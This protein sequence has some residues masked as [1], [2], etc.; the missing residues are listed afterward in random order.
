MVDARVPP[1]KECK[2][3]GKHPAVI[4]ADGAGDAQAADWPRDVEP[5]APA[6]N[7]P[8]AAGVRLAAVRLVAVS[9]R[10]KSQSR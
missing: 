4:G 7:L 3:P 2:R 1:Q 9:R 6:W 10:A 8:K 5:E